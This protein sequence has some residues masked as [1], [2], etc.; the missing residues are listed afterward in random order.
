M[1]SYLVTKAKIF[2][3]KGIDYYYDR[4]IEPDSQLNTI[5]LTLSGSSTFAG[6][7]LQSSPT[8]RPG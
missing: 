8:G 3:L 7:V 2:K 4:K 1:V 5:I 6:L